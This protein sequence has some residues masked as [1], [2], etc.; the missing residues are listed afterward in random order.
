MTDYGIVDEELVKAAPG[1]VAGAG[2]E[3]DRTR[4]KD[5]LILPLFSALEL[6]TNVYDTPADVESKVI[7]ALQQIKYKPI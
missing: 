6:R 2:L 5:H 1:I 4:N 3:L 7:L